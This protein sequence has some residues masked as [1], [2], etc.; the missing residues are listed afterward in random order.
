MPPRQLLCLVVGAP[1]L[2]YVLHPRKMSRS[3]LPGKVVV[4]KAHVAKGFLVRT[5]SAD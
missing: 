5:K 3:T 2:F 4:E 1:R